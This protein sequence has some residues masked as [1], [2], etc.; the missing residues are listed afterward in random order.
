MLTMAKR[1]SG[2]RKA[3]QRG[4]RSGEPVN[5]WVPVELMDMV[6][7]YVSAQQVRTSKTAVIEAAVRE[8]LKAQGFWPPPTPGSPTP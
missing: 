6:R 5:V 2:R 4:P 3:P 1:K 7:A 8:F